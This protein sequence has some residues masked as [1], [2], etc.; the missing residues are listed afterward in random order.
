VLVRSKKGQNPQDR[1]KE[2]LHCKVII[3]NK[4]GSL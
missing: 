1:L 4:W 3:K 2:F